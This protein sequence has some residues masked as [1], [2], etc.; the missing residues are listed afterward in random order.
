MDREGKGKDWRQEMLHFC[1][2]EDLGKSSENRVVDN[3]ERNEEEKRA[4]IHL[5]K[6]RVQRV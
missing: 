3:I 2:K 1:G 5:F 4:V 6:A